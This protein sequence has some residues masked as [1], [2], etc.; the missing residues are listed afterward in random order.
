MQDVQQL[1][2]LLKSQ[3]L[4]DDAV[5]SSVLKFYELLVEENKVQNLT[6]LISPEDF[7]QGHLIDVL[8]LLKA[9]VLQFPAFDLGSGAGVP[10]LLAAIIE[11]SSKP[12]VLCD[13][14]KSK[15][16]F[17]ARVASSLSL[18]HVEVHAGR[19]EDYLKTKKAGSVVCRA[20]GNVQK[21]Y[22][23][24]RPCST[25]NNLILFKGPNW[26]E[27][28]KDAPRSAKLM[29]LK[30]KN[31]KKYFVG[32]EKKERVLLEVVRL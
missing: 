20:V 19:A 9:D 12:W 32:A 30:V 27:E 1:E 23:W 17:L 22:S 29:E 3:K 14:E 25:W 6:R 31:T 16:L 18:N 10:G 7:I 21:I 5:L 13:S 24:L 26:E 11:N 28:W 2:S 4:L 8:E 15:A